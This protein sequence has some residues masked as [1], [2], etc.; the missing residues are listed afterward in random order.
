MAA[1]SSR[2]EGAKGPWEQGGFGWFAQEGAEVEGS[3]RRK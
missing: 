1:A 3:P 2:W